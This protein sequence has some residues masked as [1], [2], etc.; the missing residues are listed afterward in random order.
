MSS[1]FVSSTLPLIVI[2][3]ASDAIIFYAAYLALSVWRGLAVPIYRSR[4]LW[5]AFLAILFS[6]A[7]PFSVNVD[8]I[9]PEAYRFVASI[10]IYNVLYTL[11]IAVLFGWIDRTISTVIRLDYLRR[12]LLGWR[13]FRFVYW[14]F[15]A[16]SLVL[17]IFSSPSVPL[18]AIAGFVFLLVTLTYASIAL[19]MGSRR[20]LDMTFRSH[21]RWGGYCM[22]AIILTALT[23]VATSNVILSD[24][25]LLL[26]SYSLYKM[27]KSLVPVGTFAGSQSPT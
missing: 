3:V 26:I 6:F 21:A 13:R 24:L 2:A 27:A 10:V 17:N 12:D 8:T 20:T 15:A 14:G 23:F 19:V 4:A 11:V 16:G 25:P 7:A 1:D 9:F 18:I 5:T 22:L